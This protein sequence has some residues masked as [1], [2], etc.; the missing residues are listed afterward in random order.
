MFS[1]FR[2]FLKERPVLPCLGEAN[3]SNGVAANAKPRTVS[4]RIS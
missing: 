2:S 4:V 3:P 1:P